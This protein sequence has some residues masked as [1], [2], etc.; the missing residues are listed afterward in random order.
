MNVNLRTASPP[1]ST[2]ATHAEPAPYTHRMHIPWQSTLARSVWLGIV[3]GADKGNMRSSQ[4]G[5]QSTK[6]CNVPSQ[7]SAPDRF[8]SNHQSKVQK[9]ATAKE[10]P[11]DQIPPKPNRSRAVSRFHWTW[12]SAPFRLRCHGPPSAPRLP[13][14]RQ[15][16]NPSRAPSHL[17]HT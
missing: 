14:T 12:F 13:Q 1:L 7:D 15:L 3:E 6:R 4:G 2:L 16:A 9:P 8:R 17:H 5:M 11:V 10:R